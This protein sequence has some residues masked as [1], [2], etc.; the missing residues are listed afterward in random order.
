MTVMIILAAL[1]VTMA[2]FG[3]YVRKAREYQLVSERVWDRF[4][5]A[6]KAVVEDRTMPK[7]AA[8]LVGALVLCTGC[9]CFATH[10][11]FDWLVQLGR[12]PVSRRS[13]LYEKMTPAQRSAFFEVVSSAVLYDALQVPLRGF[14]LR[15]IAYPWLDAAGGD[16]RRIKPIQRNVALVTDAAWEVAEKKPEAR[17]VLVMAG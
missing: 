11:L 8:G 3:R 6:A 13:A 17:R 10:A 5:E 14:I 9:G 15:R 12:K 7:E 1:I 2:S 16:P 4:Y